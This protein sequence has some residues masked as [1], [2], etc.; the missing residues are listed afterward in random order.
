[1][2]T[3]NCVYDGKTDTVANFHSDS[4]KFS[5]KLS[6]LFGQSILTEVGKN[7]VNT[8][9]LSTDFFLLQKE[10]SFVEEMMNLIVRFGT[11]PINNSSDLAIKIGFAKKGGILTPKDLNDIAEICRRIKEEDIP[12]M[13]ENA[14]KEANPLYP[15][16]RLMDAEQLSRMFKKVGGLH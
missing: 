15:V 12:Q 4:K 11:L 1:M 10:L 16:P 6:N 3:M 13:A 7:L 2:V 8:L 5:I 9:E 14:D